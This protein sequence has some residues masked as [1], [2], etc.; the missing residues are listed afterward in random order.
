MN[1]RRALLALAILVLGSAALPTSGHA[2]TYFFTESGTSNFGDL[3]AP[4]YGS[5][6]VTTVGSDLKFELG[7]APNWFVDSGNA[8]VHHPVAFN[9]ATSGLTISGSSGVVTPLAS[10]FAG[11]NA[12]GYTNPGFS[13]PFNYAINCPS[14][15]A[16]ACNNITS[17]TFYVL[18]AGLL[19]LVPTNGVYIT[20]DIYNPSATG[21]KTGAVGATIAPVP[22]PLMGAGLPGLIAACAGLVAFARRRR[23]KFA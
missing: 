3:A 20:A 8:T 16:G 4:G 18:G 19:S 6:T 11:V 13:G 17:L 2:I 22:S 1:F 9:L 23:Q 7:L 14:N 21:E 12:G 10:P 5:V 15:G